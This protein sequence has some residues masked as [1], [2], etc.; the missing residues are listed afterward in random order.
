MSD[1]YLDI[2]TCS[3][4]QRPDFTNDAIIAISYQQIDSRTGEAKGKLNI[5]KSWESSEE[6]IL[7]EFHPIF[8]PEEKWGFI[9]IGC[10]LS[11][12]FTTL[13]YRFK[14]IGIAINARNLFAEHPYID[15][16]PILIMFNR[17]SFK[18]AALEKFTRKRYPGSKIIEW[19][20]K[21]DYRAIQDYIE[22]EAA[23]FL[24]LYKFLVRR[25]PDV[26]LEFAKEF[27]III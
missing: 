5:L 14:K 19:Y 13:I 26:W 1:Y 15:I 11:F 6:E 4:T 21:K 8:N 7:Q 18:G 12:D 10:N 25:L 24:E 23:S 2:E 16:Q 20:D 17:G 3:R 22:D 9:P 27:Q